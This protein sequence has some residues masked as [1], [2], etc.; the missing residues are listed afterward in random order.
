VEEDTNSWKET[1]WDARVNDDR[2]LVRAL[3]KAHFGER[4]LLFFRREEQRRASGA[5]VR[6][7]R[8][9]LVVF[10][11]DGRVDTAVSYHGDAMVPVAR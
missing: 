11:Y 1:R 7:S 8:R 10:Q 2:G 5:H 3:A 6:Q 4:S 9:L